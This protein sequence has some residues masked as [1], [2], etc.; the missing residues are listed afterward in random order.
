MRPLRLAR[1]CLALTFVAAAGALAQPASQRWPVT[2]QQ[3]RTADQVA[4]AGVPLSELA[5]NAPDT[6]TVKRGD[7][8]WDIS[9]I[10]LRSPWRW[11]EL[12]GMNKQQIANPHLIYPGQTLVLIRGADGRA[13][14]QVAD[15]AGLP[16]APG[17]VVK[18]SPRVR[19]ADAER[20]GA[21]PSIPNNLIEPFLSQPLVVGAN[22][23]ARYP[24]IVA[25]PEGRVNLGRGDT[26]YARGIGEERVENYHVFRPAQ[27]LF[28]PDDE[29][30]RNPIA[31]EAMY[32]GTARLVKRG[33]VATL[34]IQD[35]KQEIG[36]GDRLVPIERQPLIAYVP[37]RPERAVD[38]RIVSVYG[39]V[40]QAGPQSIVALNRGRA[41]GLE[42][43]HVLALLE[44]GATV[45]DRTVAGREFVKLP[46]E[47]IGTMFVFRVFD[48]IAYALIM[49]ATKP[50]KVGDRFA[51][52]D[53]VQFADADPR[54]AASAV[55]MA[56][57]VGGPQTVSPMR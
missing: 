15:G 51:Q 47:R 10:F 46:D 19:V 11:P 53:D 30:R 43:G 54:P 40:A 37:R 28:D 35:S 38:G 20:A 25:T 49:T 7:T 22:E 6:Y 31:Y 41:D 39:G 5:P 55:P 2:D 17:D 42:I 57:P 34:R 16:G 48:R 1:A 23:L 4:Q 36:V 52:P 44:T 33:E 56:A 18:L 45:R 26:A 3:R 50:V 14:L 29:A 21:I 24:R 8:L 12:W 32:L 27:P 9:S 13:R